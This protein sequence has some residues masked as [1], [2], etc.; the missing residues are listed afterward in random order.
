MNINYNTYCMIPKDLLIFAVSSSKK[1]SK[2]A[3]TK[4]ALNNMEFVQ[5]EL[6][7]I[8]FIIPFKCLFGTNTK[9]KGIKSLDFNNASY[10]D[11][12]RL[13]YC[14]IKKSYCY[15]YVFEMQY[16]NSKTDNNAYSLN[17]TLAS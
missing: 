15:A 12:F 7:G 5:I 6:Y 16:Y 17:F 9:I 8:R 11:S 13:G 14:N 4:K 1:N 10:C 3:M 2:Y